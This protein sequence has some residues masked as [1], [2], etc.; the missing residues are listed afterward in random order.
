MLKH[1]GSTAFARFL[2]IA[3]VTSLTFAVSG[4]AAT[5]YMW[6]DDSGVKQY[7]DHCPPDEKCVA[8]KVGPSDDGDTGGGTKNKGKSW[9][10]TT[11][12]DTSSTDTGTTSTSGGD[13][14][15]DTTADSGTG[16]TTPDTTTDSGTGD[17]TPDTTTDSGTGDTTPD[18]TT[19][20]E[21][22]TTG[23]ASTPTG[24]DDTATTN[25]NPISDASAD[26]Q[27]DP[28]VHATLSGYHVFYAKAGTDYQPIDVGNTTT[29]SMA[30]LENGTR[31]YFRV[32]AY[33]S[34][35]NQSG[36]SNEVYKDMP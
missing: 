33:D 31:Y 30:G 28:V 24:T 9:K 29:Y 27:W 4:E 22:T 10:N 14:T 32:A 17:T 26:L 23:D 12:A 15:A 36:F 16:D 3:L 1:N 5:V 7:T 18:T 21:P 11:T 8:K 34:S 25:T 6:R 2:A 20:S 35:G 13:S 19:D